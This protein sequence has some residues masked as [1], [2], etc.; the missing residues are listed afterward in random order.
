M[1]MLYKISNW[2]HSRAKG[3][4]ILSVLG[5][6]VIFM[7][8]LL[9]I[10]NHIYPASVKMISL[11]D[12]VFYTPTEIFSIV[13]S[14]GN[15]GRTLQFWFHLTW[16]FIV[17]IL[18]LLFIGL[19][20]SWLLQR[21]FKPESK[22]QKLNLVALASIFDLLE[23]FCIAIIILAYPVRPMVIAWMKIVFTLSKYGFGV[24][25]ILLILA[26]LV[27]TAKNRFRIQ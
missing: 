11:D 9:P 15:D 10:F 24:L 3:R 6:F 5:S 4:L 16:D 1:K 18:G 8:V 21:S 20:L 19:F 14:W 2:F 23:N 13:E 26:G 7:G 25:I 22:L 17:P 12:P 27:I